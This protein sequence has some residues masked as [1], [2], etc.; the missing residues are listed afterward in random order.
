MEADAE[1]RRRSELNALSTRPTSAAGTEDEAMVEANRGDE[2]RLRPRAREVSPQP[3]APQCCLQGDAG[4]DLTSAKNRRG[5]SRA[6]RRP[7]RVP[8][9]FRGIGPSFGKIDLETSDYSVTIFSV[10]PL[11]DGRTTIGRHV[12]QRI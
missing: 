5:A 4:K 8:R 10:G 9:A 12:I 6:P 1:S 7:R 2:R 11:K 3:G